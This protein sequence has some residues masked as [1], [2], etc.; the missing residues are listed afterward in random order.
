MA[1]LTKEA[2]KM[3]RQMTFQ[4]MINTTFSP[5]SA[6][7]LTP[8]ALPAGQTTGLCGRGLAPANLSARQAREKGLTTS[9]TSGP[10]LNGSFASMALQQYL[11]NRLRGS[12]GGSGSR[13]CDLI[14]K[15]QDM[16][17]G[18]PICALRA[19]GRG[20]NAQGITGLPTP[21]GCSNGGKNHVVGRLDEWGGS[22]NPWRGSEIGKKRCASFEAWMMGYPTAWASPTVLEMLSFRPLRKR[23]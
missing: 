17:L 16:P 13:W 6:D 20:T 11:E 5:V 4:D 21:S 1:T 22:S 23:S 9:A 15:P 12:L 3:S 14:W 10:R 7:G 8:F 19:S 18:L 2:L